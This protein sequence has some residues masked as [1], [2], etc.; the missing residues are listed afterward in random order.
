MLNQLKIRIS[1]DLWLLKTCV[2]ARVLQRT[3]ENIVFLF[4]EK[5]VL[6]FGQR[7]KTKGQEDVLLLLRMCNSFLQSIYYCP[8][9]T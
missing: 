1:K 4:I 7:R 9:N 3:A 8:I 2:F 5:R 6:D